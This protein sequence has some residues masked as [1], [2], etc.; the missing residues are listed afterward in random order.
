[1]RRSGM[2][3]RSK[4]ASFSKNQISCSNTGPR[5]PAVWVFWLSTTG[6]PD[7]VVSLFDGFIAIPFKKINL[8]KVSGCAPQA[9]EPFR[10]RACGGS[11]SSRA[12]HPPPPAIR[13]DEY[14][15]DEQLIN[16][17]DYSDE[18]DSHALSILQDRV[19]AG[20]KWASITPRGRGANV[21]VIKKKIVVG[22]IHAPPLHGA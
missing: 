7:A 13:L 2:T 20:R 18:I 9:L 3:S 15:I 19:I 11:E 22:C 21:A 16:L 5:G 17:I 12:A 14:A 1:M 4:C 10:W 8:C 6:A